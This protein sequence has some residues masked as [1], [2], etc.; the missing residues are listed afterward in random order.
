MAIRWGEVCSDLPPEIYRVTLNYEG[1][2]QNDP[3]DSGNYLISNGQRILVGT[4][5]GIT[6][7]AVARAMDMGHLRREPITVE[8]MKN[9]TMK[10]TLVIY[11][12]LYY[13]PCGADKMPYPL[14]LIHFDT[15]ILHGR[16][17]SSG[18]AGFFLQ[19]TLKAQGYP[20]VID[21]AVGPKTIEK[22]KECLANLQVDK[23]GDG[24]TLDD[25][26]NDYLAFRMVS[27]LGIVQSKPE[28]RKY[29]AGWRNRVN[30]L[31]VYVD[32]H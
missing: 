6:P 31:R 2:Y 17:N 23:N 27:Y 11:D 22:L 12:R 15:A 7:G 4:N 28:K 5:R 8:Y 26:C 1:G 20:V 18:G 29:L 32:N 25:F 14:S 19:M 16:G 3:E 9:L 30:K 21:G 24:T 13:D 10:E